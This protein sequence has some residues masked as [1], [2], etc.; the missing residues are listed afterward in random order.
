[1]PAGLGGLS[2]S[3]W[4][5]QGRRRRPRI[6]HEFVRWRMSKSQKKELRD[7]DVAEGGTGLAKKGSSSPEKAGACLIGRMGGGGTRST[8]TG[9]RIQ[10]TI[11]AREGT[12]AGHVR[13]CCLFLPVRQPRT[14]PAVAS[15]SKPIRDGLQPK[16]E[17]ISG[18]LFWLSS[19]HARFSVYGVTVGGRCAGRVRL[20]GKWQ[21]Q[22]AVEPERRR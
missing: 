17:A 1:M 20:H 10:W 18:D 4:R 3:S 12:K 22:L 2:L 9:Y 16:T 6:C 11:A 13:P 5:A 21:A 7:A 15:S 14:Y 8:P 19:G